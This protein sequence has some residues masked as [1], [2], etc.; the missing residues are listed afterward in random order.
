MLKSSISR[1]KNS[2]L[3]KNIHKKQNKQFLIARRWVRPK[4]Q[5]WSWR[6][7]GCCLMP[8]FGWAHRAIT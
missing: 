3:F 4:T 8:V 7:A 6:E 1:L 2:E 5:R